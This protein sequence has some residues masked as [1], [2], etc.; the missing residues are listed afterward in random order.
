MQVI[1]QDRKINRSGEVVS[2][3]E[4]GKMSVELV[5]TFGDRATLDDLLY[6]IACHKLSQ[7][8]KQK[9]DNIVLTGENGIIIVGK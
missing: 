6:S 2:K 9:R 4:T 3:Y 7:R 8:L 1:A 5:G